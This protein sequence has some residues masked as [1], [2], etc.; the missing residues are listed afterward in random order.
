MRRIACGPA[1][2]CAGRRERQLRDLNI[3]FIRYFVTLVECNKFNK[4]AYEL[5]I[6]QPALSKSIM[7]LEDYLGT[8]LLKRFPRG[9]ELTEAGKYFYETSVYFLELYDDF[10]YDIDSRV[11]SPYS[12][13]VRISSSGVLLDMFY[14]D[15]IVKLREK[16]PAIKV[17]AKEEDTIDAI[18]S[19]LSHKSDFG[20]AIYPIPK[21]VKDSFRTY[22]LL[23]ASFHIV[24]PRDHPLAAKSAVHVSDLND[25][26][27]L[28]PGEFSQ[29]HQSFVSLC[30][31]NSVS[32]SIMCSCSQIHFL[33]RLTQAKVGLAIL[34]SVFLRSL[35]A[36]L[37]H[38]LLL[39]VL[40]WRLILISP[41]N[42][43]SLAVATT[44]SFVQNYFRSVNIEDEPEMFSR[45]MTGDGSPEE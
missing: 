15:I 36:D 42:V 32:P 24:M 38:R 18:Q 12:G 37:T 26:E 13:M 35:P 27:I 6:S 7:L 21:E 4:A 40:P 10:L 5:H 14:P 1:D 22:P 34:P 45:P 33:L 16:Y 31:E 44:I 43:T 3:S 41:N 39:P 29:V 9:F 23:E 8:A 19:L 17:F 2:R 30:K 25:V 20:T 28:T 11:C